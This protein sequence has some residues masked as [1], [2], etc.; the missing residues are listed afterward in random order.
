LAAHA[1]AAARATA[2]AAELEEMKQDVDRQ[3]RAQ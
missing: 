3:A 2:A 1:D